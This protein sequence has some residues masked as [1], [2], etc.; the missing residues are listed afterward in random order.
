MGEIDRKLMKRAVRE[1]LGRDPTSEA[2]RLATEARVVVKACLANPIRAADMGPGP[3][4]RGYVALPHWSGLTQAVPEA[5][6]RKL[7]GADSSAGD[8]GAGDETISVGRMI[9]DSVMGAGETKQERRMRKISA[10]E[11]RAERLGRR[12]AKA[13]RAA[14]TDAEARARTK[15]AKVRT[16]LARLRRKAAS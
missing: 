4:Y 14:D 1:V 12:I 6:V 7:L 5:E 8:A 9:A 16:K 13:A 11:Q 15:A 3:G 2:E 10:L